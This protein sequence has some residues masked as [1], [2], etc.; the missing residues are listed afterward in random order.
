MFGFSRRRMK[1][2][3]LKVQLSDTAQGTRSPI[4]PN[5]RFNSSNG[6]GVAAAN[7][8]ADDLNFHSSSSGTE[9]NN[10]AS[11]GSENWMVL[12][13]SGEKP[14]PRFNHAAAV[15]GNKM[16]V[17]GGESSNGLL[18]DVQV[19][20]FDRFSWTPVSSKLYLSPTSL[21]LKIPAC[22]G[23][24]LVPWGKKV[25]L[26]GGKTES[27]SDRVSVWAFDME[28]E[29]WSLIEA[30]GDIPTARSGHTVV[31]ANSVLIL[32]GGD[33]TKRR[34]LNDLH[35]FDLKSLTWLPLHCTGPR[36]CSRSNHIA[37]LYNDKILFVF[38]GASKSR[39]LNDLY[40]LDFEAMVWTRIKVHGFHPSPRAGCSGALCG[41]KWYITGGGSKKKRPAETLIFD[42]LKYTWSVAVASL[43]SSITTNKGFSLVLVQHKERDFL[44]AFGGTKKDPS[45]QV[46]VLIMEKVESSM[47]RRST[48][49]KVAGT[50]LSE[51]NNSNNSTSIGLSTQ[52]GNASI[53][54][55]FDT[56]S[57]INLA[58]AIEQHGSGRKS[59]SESLLVD[60]NSATGN[61]SLR[62]QFY[63]EETVEVTTTKSLEDK[64]SFRLMEQATKPLD[65]GAGNAEEASPMAES[66]KLS[67]DKQ[68]RGSLGLEGEELLCQETNCISMTT[69]SSGVC[70]THGAKLASLLRKNSLLEGQLA[71]A[72]AAREAVEKNSSSANKSR[73]EMENRLGDA[74]KEMEL[75]KEKLTSIELAQEEANSLSNIVH[76]DN[77]R[78]EHDV[79]FLKA[80]L[81]DTQKELHSTRGVL[82]GERARA[83]Q[84]QV[85][86][87]HLKQRL[88]SLETRA[89][90][91]RKPYQM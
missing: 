29:C 8:E 70:Q 63:N 59:L 44:V 62:K 27:V 17:V 54:S 64:K 77:V 15:I 46:E 78:L 65:S 40:S 36:P 19:L 41:T 43:P 12:S 50:L 83:F 2:G 4:R 60:P 35:M 55:N 76:S 69:D 14:T 37:A 5:K 75:L 38:G 90:T 87:F 11:G 25:L 73:Q 56:V 31:R 68:G 51:N 10:C 24:V 82:A 72:I 32:F 52:P 81:D 79:A 26:I 57:K 58:S 84:L 67:F 48:L 22:K 42:V 33:D 28:A 18:E 85:E 6:E 34:K 16:V 49:S 61:V 89:P 80:V 1:L 7:S 91:P 88:Q 3:R 21:P 30:K 9:L 20:S 13:I 86:V 66:G 71:A 74:M 47:I 45:N 39:T 23:H 53:S